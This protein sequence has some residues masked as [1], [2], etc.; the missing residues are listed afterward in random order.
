[1]YSTA[2]KVLVETGWKTLYAGLL[3][4]SASAVFATGIP[5][6]GCYP[7]CVG[8]PD[9]TLAIA[10]LAVGLVGVLLAVAGRRHAQR[11]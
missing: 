7:S 9:P 10:G 5:T 11:S 6:D 2:S 8:T 3:S 4:V 1:M